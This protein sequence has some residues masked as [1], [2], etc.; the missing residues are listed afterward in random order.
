MIFL[1]KNKLVFGALD[2]FVDEDIEFSRRLISEGVPTELRVYPGAFHGFDL[3]ETP[4]ALRCR[5][6]LEAA[7]ARAIQ[8]GGA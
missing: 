6:D 4:I 1:R 2:L 5:H 7:I 8:R 3:G